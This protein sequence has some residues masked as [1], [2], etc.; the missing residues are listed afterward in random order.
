MLAAGCDGD[1]DPTSD[2]G[3]ATA[4][5]ATDDGS[6]DVPGSSG[7]P[8]SQTDTAT[9][10]D[11]GGSGGE[12]SCEACVECVAAACTDVIAACNANA[13]CAAIYTCTSACTEQTPDD[14]IM[15]NPAGLMPWAAVSACLN[16][17]CLA[18]CTY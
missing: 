13:D 15:Q 4:M 7:D 12:A 16:D 10:T 5:P 8:G 1:D 11:D 6:G 14:C 2:T 9:S 18:V 3:A 17:N